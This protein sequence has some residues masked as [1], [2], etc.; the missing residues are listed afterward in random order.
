MPDQPRLDVYLTQKGHAPS[1]SKAQGMIMAGLIKVNG[2][3]V[4]KAGHRVPEGADIEVKGP[5][6]PFVSRGGLKLAGALDNF[7]LDP[8]G[9]NCLDVG[10]ST[11]GFT[12]CLLQRGAARVTAVDVGYGQ[13]DW[14]LRNHS[15]VEVLERVNVRHIPDDLAPGPFDLIAIDVSFISLTLIIPPLLARMTAHGCLLPMVKPQFE[16]GKDKVGAGGVVRDESTRMQTV[17]KIKA[18][19]IGAGLEVR[20]P[21]PSPIKGPAGNQEYFLLAAAPKTKK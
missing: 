1:R 13:L 16:A 4:S 3:V 19:L 15:R 12:D 21:Y 18:L 11:G 9:M 6:H 17:K 10:A 8:S 2:Q 7:G 14:K 20:G 5:E